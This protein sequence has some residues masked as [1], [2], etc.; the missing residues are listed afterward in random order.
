MFV[1]K[2]EMNTDE[3]LF[4]DFRPI[5]KTEWIAKIQKDLKGKPFEK[6]F[7]Q[8]EKDLSVSPFFMQ[9]DI[10]NLPHINDELSQNSLKATQAGW[11]TNE[12]FNLNSTKL[13]DE[14][15]A[16][17]QN[18]VTGFT[19]TVSEQALPILPAFFKFIETHHHQIRKIS[20]SGSNQALKKLTE[21]HSLAEIIR[22][23]T[24]ILFSFRFNFLSELTRDGKQ[25]LTTDFIPLLQK[26]FASYS[27]VRYLTV[28]ADYFYNAG[29]SIIQELAY[30]L[31]ITKHYLSFFN[32]AD[33][34]C[35]HITFL[36]AIGSNYFV[37]IAKL[38]A[39]RILWSKLLSLHDSSFN[40]P[41]QIFIGSE[42]AMLNKT[43]YDPFVNM[44]RNTTEAMA[45][46]IGGT[47]ELTVLPFNFLFKTNDDFGKR[48]ARNVQHLLR[49]ETHLDK[50]QDISAG[51]YYIENLTHILAEKAWQLFTDN[52]SEGG[53]ETLFQNGIIKH[54][55]EQNAHQLTNKFNSRE[56]VLVGINNYPNIS[57]TI[58]EK[59]NN[60]EIK[61]EPDNNKGLRF[62]RLAQNLETLRLSF[63]KS[64]P[65][66][67]K[68]FL[69]TYGNLAMRRARAGFA[70]NFLGAAGFDIYDNNGFS[71]IDEGMTAFEK[72]DADILVVC[73]SDEE[74]PEILP[75]IVN[76]I[77]DKIVIVAGNPKNIT[78]S[79]NVDY[80][81]YA[82]SN[83]LD[84]LQKIWKQL[85]KIK[86]EF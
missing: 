14:L 36:F 68:A 57:E 25:S 3:R 41:E 2:S 38:R 10:K 35:S 20:F 51:S 26:Q 81:I 80:Y 52:E 29:S 42:T 70:L 45:A 33:D 4:L 76:H 8:P 7:W 15:S 39:F 72:S 74:Y 75:T 19:I 27:N 85:L 34:A 65:E 23:N 30:T 17:L 16:G 48:I 18:D 56:K 71:S 44:L 37:E 69:F 58:L 79:A 43:I 24:E 12:H 6:L 40:T 5:T 82:G 62:F 78:V 31:G 64:F 54:T 66:R 86:G 28:N 47:N 9:E 50:T 46:I 84:T 61:Q 59:I 1:K 77:R 63:E 49:Y 83:I 11:I 32:S 21:Q 22:K 67:T 73:S 60:G 53:Y 55:I 13:L